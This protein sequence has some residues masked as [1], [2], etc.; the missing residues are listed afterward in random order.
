VT[1]L[2]HD[3]PLT[4]RSYGPATRRLPAPL[5]WTLYLL[6]AVLF[7][8]LLALRGGPGGADAPAV[9]V[10]TTAISHG[11]VRGALPSALED[12]NP[13]GYPLMAAAFV[14]ALRPLVGASDWCVPVGPL[15]AHANLQQAGAAGAGAR[16]PP[17]WYHSQA[18]LVVLAWLVLE[19]GLIVLLHTFGV[20]ATVLEALA[21]LVVALAPATTDAVVAAY[22][23]QDLLCV[24]LL[25]L[26][27]AAALGQRWLLVGLAFGAAFL[28][29]QFALLALFPVLVAAPGGRARL[30]AAG[31]AASLVVVIL[32]PFVALEPVATLHSLQATGILAVPHGL[33]D[34]VVGSATALPLGARSAIARYGPFL[35]VAVICGYGWSRR[36]ELRAPTALVGLVTACLASRLVFEAAAFRYYLL[37]A[38]VFLV[39]LDCA[40]RRWPVRSVAWI[41]L[42]S[43]WWQG[44]LPAAV[45]DAL[46]PLALLA[47][48]G[49]AIWLGLDGVRRPPAS[50]PRLSAA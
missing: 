48:A 18:L 21:L 23:P 1:P 34:T 32:A 36:R 11:H 7:V 4:P 28:A 27:V 20:G 38:S 31:T 43:L 16:R 40:W 47:A 5:Q 22:H 14:A 9:V 39:C 15:C 3:H 37:A 17:P 50:I 12:P 24:G 8:A 49:T 42:T 6:A 19:A 29:K 46:T 30:V 2:A 41:A 26:G 10:P 33:T 35:A 13:P 44:W 25:L 45:L